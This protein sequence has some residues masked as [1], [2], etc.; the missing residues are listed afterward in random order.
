MLPPSQPES[1][2]G[3]NQTSCGTRLEFTHSIGRPYC[4][5]VLLW[6]GLPLNPPP[7]GVLREIPCPVSPARFCSSEPFFYIYHW[8]LSPLSTRY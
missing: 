7:F 8:A 6:R 4:P 1:A 5:S 3:N 2:F